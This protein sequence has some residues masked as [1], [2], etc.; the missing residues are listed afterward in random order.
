[1]E[2][3]SRF[4]LL[5]S[6]FLAFAAALSYSISIASVYPSNGS[7]EGGTNVTIM[8]SGFATVLGSPS[9]YACTGGSQSLAIPAGVTKINVKLWGAAGGGRSGASGGGGYSSGDIAVTPGETLTLIVG[10]G[11]HGLSGDG[12]GGYGGGGTSGG[13]GGGGGR[14]AVRRSSTELI[15]A[16]GGGGGDDDNSGQ[17]GA[18]GGTSGQSGV[19][20]AHGYG[21]TQTAGGSYGGSA[22]QG[23]G[24]GYG[25]GGGG[26]YYGGGATNSG[27]GGGAGGG[28]GYIGGVT[29]GVTTSGSATAPGNSADPDRG[30]SIG[31]GLANGNGNPGKIV[32]RSYSSSASPPIVRIG[33]V[34]CANVSV[35][36][37]TQ[38]TCIAP[39]HASGLSDIVLTDS[40]N[41]SANLAGGYQFYAP[42]NASTF[43]GASTNLS[44]VSDL[45]S[46]TNFTLDKPGRGRIRFPSS[47]AVNTAGQDYDANVHIGTSFVSVNSSALDPSFNSSAT[48]T[49]DVPGA[50]FG[51]IQP[52]IYYYH[53]FV[54]SANA[55]LQ[56]GTLCTA[57]RCT[58]ITWD[59]NAQTVT[60]N[61]SGFSGYAIAGG[62]YGF[63]GTLGIN[64]TSTNQIAVYTASAKNNS[65]L[66]FVPATPPAAGSIILSSNESRNVTGGDTGFLVENQGNINV[67]ITVS[68]DKDAASFIGGSSPLFQMFGAENKISSCPGINA[69]AQDLG[70]SAITVCPSLAFLDSQDTI[71]AYVLVKIGSDSPPQANTATLTFTSTQV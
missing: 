24:S 33:G 25:P 35:V 48:I 28:S 61:V 1:M 57:P 43:G 4:L 3:K 19:G 9:S 7:A 63:T 55:I 40:F 23:G 64:I 71:W 15:T 44:N 14:S 18:G 58:G 68:S 13:G 16:A 59:N 69:T 26:G 27:G 70:A 50:G 29:N 5:V 17:A 62:Q 37:D 42:P 32:V 52:S 36:S 21:A 22:F 56:N 65:A 34:A 8:G 47:H 11:G 12:A 46:V 41:N 66:S 54:S 38:L 10:C 31:Y 67:S 30:G 49:L 39:A 51:S 60:F 53:D 20:P 6:V 45:S 2:A